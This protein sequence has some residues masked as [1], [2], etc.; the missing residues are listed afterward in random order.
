MIGL[1]AKVRDAIFRQDFIAFLRKAYEILY[2][3]EARPEAEPVSENDR[4]IIADF[5]RRSSIP[6]PRDENP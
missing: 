1:T 2:P 4:V 6:P 5:L 3:G